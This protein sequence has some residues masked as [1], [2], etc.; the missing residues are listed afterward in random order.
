MDARAY[1]LSGYAALARSAGKPA[2]DAPRGYARARDGNGDFLL[3]LHPGEQTQRVS[4]SGVSVCMLRDCGDSHK[5][6][7]HAADAR[8][9][10]V[11]GRACACRAACVSDSCGR[12]H[13]GP[14]AD[15]GVGSGNGACACGRIARMDSEAAAGGNSVSA[16]RGRALHI[17][18]VDCDAC[19][20]E[21]SER[22]AH[23]RR[24]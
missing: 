12:R 22:R 10:V 16:V 13:S 23:R 20:A 5:I 8:L 7:E 1:R 18:R 4:P 11:Y 14:C 19:R 17:L 9:R 2:A 6:R 24:A 21:P 3:L 15:S